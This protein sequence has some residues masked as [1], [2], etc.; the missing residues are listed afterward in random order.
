MVKKHMRYVLTFLL[1]PHTAHQRKYRRK[2]NIL[3]PKFTG[4]NS[5]GEETFI[6]IPVVNV[7]GEQSR[8]PSHANIKKR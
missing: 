5:R 2:Y 6:F 7:G 1:T 8:Q 4:Q 3:Y